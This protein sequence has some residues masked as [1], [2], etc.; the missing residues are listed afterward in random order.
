MAKDGQPQADFINCIAWGKSAEFVAK[1][2]RKGQQIVVVGRIQTR[3]W[4]DNEAR[5]H[6][7]TEII[8]EEVDFAGSRPKTESNKSDADDSGT[9]GDA[10]FYPEET[11]DELPF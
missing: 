5:K 7:V 10:G 8:I 11:D 4:E 6:Y 9:S 1:Y 2:F 3:T